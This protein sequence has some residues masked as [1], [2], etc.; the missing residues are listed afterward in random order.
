MGGGSYDRDVGCTRSSSGY[1]HGAYTPKAK[2]TLSKPKVDKLVLPKGRIITCEHESPVW[3]VIDGTGSMGD[4]AYTIQDKMPMCYGQIILQ[5]YL[6]D[7]AILMSVTGDAS[8]DAPDKA[9]TQVG[10]FEQGTN[11]DNW[12]TRLWIEHKGGGQT[13]E[14][15]ELMAF[16]GA[17]RCEL[18]NAKMPYFFFIG[19]E[20]YYDVVDAGQ[21]QKHLGVEIGQSIPAKTI[22]RELMKKFSVW[23]IHRDYRGWQDKRIVKDWQDAIGIE[24]VVFLEEA[25]AII[26]VILGIIAKTSGTRTHDQYLADLRGEGADPDRTQTPERIAEV[27]RALMNVPEGSLIKRTA[28][29]PAKKTTK[30][31]KGGAKRIT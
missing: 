6:N 1:D 18:K 15:Y 5:S 27:S 19:D 8:P 12:L 13:R 26:D 25:K 31:R 14:S 7:P 11:I 21:V 23:Y 2:E 17:R 28:D 4:D 29:L 24:N 30:K 10:E 16:M 9:P 3:I 22:F 20:G